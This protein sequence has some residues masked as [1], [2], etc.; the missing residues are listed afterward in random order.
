MSLNVN[1]L[2]KIFYVAT[3]V[4]M[5]L[6][7]CSGDKSLFPSSTP[8]KE[9]AIG[10]IAN[11]AVTTCYAEACG[12][13]NKA[14]TQAIVDDL[15]QYVSRGTLSQRE[16]MEQFALYHGMAGN[17][18]TSCNTNAAKGHMITYNEWINKLN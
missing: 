5:V 13:V 9:S 17:S 16:I 6:S 1:R 11:V 14:D 3:I 10:A 15:H 8:N 2:D 12:T 7:G 4:I 18:F